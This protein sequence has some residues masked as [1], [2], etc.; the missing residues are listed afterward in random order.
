MIF[1]VKEAYSLRLFFKPTGELPI[2]ITDSIRFR[3][4]KLKTG[5]RAVA[6]VAACGA[7]HHTPVRHDGM[8][9]ARSPYCCCRSCKCQS[10][11]QFFHFISPGQKGQS[12]SKSSAGRS[13]PIPPRGLITGPDPFF[14]TSPS[15]GTSS[16]A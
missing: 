2:G 16:P 7:S 4:Q 5:G 13:S 12:W 15:S 6:A 8:S 14:G 9:C 10:N 11:D 3:S 1:F